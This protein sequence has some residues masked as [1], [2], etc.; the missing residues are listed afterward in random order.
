MEKIR[1]EL[2]W[3]IYFVLMMI[4]WMLVERLSGLHGKYLEKQEIFS[5]F[6]AIPAITI[7]VLALL[8]LRRRKY[9]GSMTYGQGFVSGLIITAVVTVFSPLVQYLTSEVISPDYFENMIQLTVSKGKM[10]QQEAEAYFNLPSYIRQVLVGTPVM[11]IAT[12]AV[13]A[14]FTRK[15]TSQQGTRA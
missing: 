13:V 12:T 11:G 15:R 14:I 10:S 5:N 4:G 2:K 9:G 6:I 8:D 1:I 7:Y 3:G